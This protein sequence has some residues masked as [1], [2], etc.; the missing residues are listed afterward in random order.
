VSYT[1]YVS[2][3]DERTRPGAVIRIYRVGDNKYVLY[4]SG[5]SHTFDAAK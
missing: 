4:G 1:E 5:Q 3:S 2:L